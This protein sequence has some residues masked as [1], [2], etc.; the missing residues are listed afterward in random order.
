MKQTRS[1]VILLLSALFIVSAVG[2]QAEKTP[3]SV[4]EQSSETSSETS[5]E[6]SS[7]ETSSESKEESSSEPEAESAEEPEK[8]DMFYTNDGLILNIPEEFW[9]KVEVTTEESDE[10]G[11]GRI[12][13]VVEKASAEAALNDGYKEEDGFG[14]VFS[15]E[16]MSPEEA[17][18]LVD[19][20]ISGAL[21]F[22]LDYRGLFYVLR[23][24]TDVRFYRSNDAEWDQDLP[25]YEGLYEWT[26]QVPDT[27]VKDNDR[28]TRETLEPQ[29]NTEADPWAAISEDRFTG[30]WACDDTTITIEKK[31]ETY[32]VKVEMTKEDGSLCTWNYTC[33]Y[34]EAEDW[35]SGVG[36]KVE[37]TV[38][39]TDELVTIRLNRSGNII[40]EDETG[41]NG[42]D[43]EFEFVS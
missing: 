8:K 23:F 15:I 20:D 1:F 9:D 41:G 22:A 31:N 28:L 14:W 32:T 2:C 11:Y 42:A 33:T 34:D 17:Q 16:R 18:Q 43:M 38:H 3:E 29:E 35:L 4:A 25:I 12:F 21:P 39:T 26:T 36:E 10:E 27:F 6:A 5:S 24:P 40:W 30:T 7:E 13:R 19:D 37:G